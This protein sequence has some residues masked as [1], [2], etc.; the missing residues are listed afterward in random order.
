MWVGDIASVHK[1]GAKRS[2]REVAVFFQCSFQ[3]LPRQVQ[4]V[5]KFTNQRFVVWDAGFGFHVLRV[6]VYI[7]SVT[8]KLHEL[9][10]RVGEGLVVV[11]TPSEAPWCCRRARGPSTPWRLRIREDAA[12]LRMTD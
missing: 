8:H 9:S 6:Q 1:S 5:A 11:E 4:V 10:P 3:V 12:A 2:A 7:F